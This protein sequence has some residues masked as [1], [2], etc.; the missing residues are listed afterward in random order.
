M[1]CECFVVALALA[2]YVCLVLC[3]I[4]LMCAGVGVWCLVELM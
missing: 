4:V 2:V 3:A 1:D